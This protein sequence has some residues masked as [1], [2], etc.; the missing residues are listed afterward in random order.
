MSSSPTNHRSL[1]V[2]DLLAASAL[3][4]C[5]I[6]ITFEAWRDILNMGLKDEEL[7]YVLL[8]PLIIGLLVW[9]RWDQEPLCRLR[10][11]WVGL[12][13][14]VAAWLIHWFGYLADPVLWRGAAVLLAVGAFATAVGWDVLLRF[15]PAF[16]ATIFL[17]P[18]DPYGRYHIAVPLQDAT[19]RA[20][21]WV[22]DAIG[23]AVERYGS[24]LSINGVEVA[25]AEGCNGMRMVLSLFLVCYVVAFMLPLRGWV[26]T[27]FLLASPLVAIFANVIRLVPTVWMFGHRTAEAAENFH[28][29]TGWIMTI[30]AFACLLGFFQ[31][32]KWLDIPVYTS[33]IG[34]RDSGFGIREAAP[35]GFFW[36]AALFYKL[37]AVMLLAAAGTHQY[38]LTHKPAGVEAYQARIRD[39]AKAVPSHIG[40][41]VCQE[42]RVASRVNAVLRP[43][44]LLSRQYTNVETNVSA[45]L[46]L[47]HCSAA[48][49]MAG[50]FPLR[51]YPAEGW[52]LQ[53]SRPRDWMVGDMCFTGT[54]Y[55]FTMEQMGQT[56]TLIVANCLLLSGGKILRD[57]NSMAKSLA[58]V[59]SQ[60]AGAGQIQ[61]CFDASASPQKRDQ[62]VVELLEGYR[63]TIEAILAPLGPDAAPSR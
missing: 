60:A 4:L 34:I 38:A 47:V 48:H 49:S 33:K 51:C 15:W 43:N 42:N 53:T 16:A 40:A 29:V 25:V 39:Q 22:C 41:W 18:I 14:I 23:I 59:G 7:S 61:I 56:R 52:V 8:A 24:T 27:V 6:G 46:L 13:I 44:V 55:S 50:H 19:A 30:V 21:Q 11:G 17:V 35:K 45:T 10:G 54:E 58:S 28:D 37:C 12:L 2:R 62:A 32:L 26:R 57:M 20:T 31:V 36:S 1:G 9:A 3:S 63:S 5:A